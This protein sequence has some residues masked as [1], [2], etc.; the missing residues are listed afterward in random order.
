MRKS[1]YNREGWVLAQ[2]AECDRLNYVEPHGTTAQCACKTL[3]RER[4]D[5]VV[6]TEHQPIPMDCRDFGGTVLIRKPPSIL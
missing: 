3:I 4:D 2:C 1:I 6:W 5:A